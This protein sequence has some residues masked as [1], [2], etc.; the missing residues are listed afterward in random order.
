MLATS[1]DQATLFALASQTLSCAH[2]EAPRYAKRDQGNCGY[3]FPCLI[4]RAALHHVGLDNPDD[5]SFDALNEPDEMAADR[6][7]DLRALVRSLSRTAL[8]IDVLRN[9]PV[10]PADVTAF[11]GVVERG[12]AEILAWLRA[13]A[14]SASLRR[15]LPS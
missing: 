12:R 4:R 1:A 5:Y 7:A 15:Q 10:P 2:P 14:T 11:S 6:G 3:C 9:G 8:P 13:A